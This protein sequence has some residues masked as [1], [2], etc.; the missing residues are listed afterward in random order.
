MFD[1]TEPAAPGA[2]RD[3]RSGKTLDPLPATGTPAVAVG[4]DTTFAERARFG[5]NP[6][7]LYRGGSRPT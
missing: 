4:T 2:D 6:D 5:A 3:R 7:G 1:E